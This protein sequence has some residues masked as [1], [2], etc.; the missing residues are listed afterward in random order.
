MKVALVKFAAGN[1]H[2]VFRV[3]IE[4]MAAL[5]LAGQIKVY[6]SDDVYNMLKKS[7]IRKIA[8]E[9]SDI[10][11]SMKSNKEILVEGEIP[12]AMVSPAK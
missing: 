1:M 5:A 8:K 6:S 12:A 10:R 3:K 11:Q 2:K 9:A 4:D 7:G